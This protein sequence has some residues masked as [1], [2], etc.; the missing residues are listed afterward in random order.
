MKNQLSQTTKTIMDANKYTIVDETVMPKEFV[1]TYNAQGIDGFVIDFAK[2]NQSKDKKVTYVPIYLKYGEED[3]KTILK[4]LFLAAKNIP[5]T[6]GISEPDEKGERE[7]GVTLPSTV[8]KATYKDSNGDD[9]PFGQAILC[10]DRLLSDV[11]KKF[12]DEIE[13][14]AGSKPKLNKLVQ[15]V[16]S[17]KNKDQQARGK[18]IE[19]P[20]F[21][22]KLRFNQDKKKKNTTCKTTIKDAN[23][24][25]T[26]VV[27]GVKKIDYKEA[28][29]NKQPISWNNIHKFIKAYSKYTGVINCSDISFSGFGMSIPMY[30]KNFLIIEPSSGKEKNPEDV[31]KGGFLDDVGKEASEESDEAD[32]NSE[33][34]EVGSEEEEEAPKPKKGKAKPKPKKVESDEEEEEGSIDS[35]DEPVKPKKSTKKAAPK[36]KPKAKPTKPVDEDEDDEEY[37]D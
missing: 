8:N 13:E 10:L 14:I 3:G 29:V 32:D 34:E 6:G 11:Y 27:N 4:K 25:Y 36:S 33:P 1:D 24:R 31:F 20:V 37:D 23:K 19:D 22:L 30:P 12:E 26:K 17:K 9:Q 7:Y 35:N 16:V 28:T 21:R 18:K 2:P 5:V 15:E